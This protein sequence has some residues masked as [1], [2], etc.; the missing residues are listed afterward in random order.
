MTKKIKGHNFYA[1]CF[2]YLTTNASIP[3]VPS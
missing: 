3:I 2:F 1:P